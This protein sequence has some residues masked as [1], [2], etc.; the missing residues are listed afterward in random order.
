MNGSSAIEIDLLEK[1]QSIHD[2]LL[3]Y[4]GTVDMSS[5]LWGKE[6][7]KKVQMPPLPVQQKARLSAI[8]GMTARQNQTDEAA[9][10]ARR[11]S[12]AQS[13]S[14][15]GSVVSSSSIR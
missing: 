2:R 11:A 8:P 14:E 6:K 12:I 13:F 9:N 15:T 1:L 10:N 4:Q 5:I 7:Q 3:E